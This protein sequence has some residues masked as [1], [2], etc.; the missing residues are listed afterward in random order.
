MKYNRSKIDQNDIILLISDIDQNEILSLISEI[1]QNEIL[2]L[3]SLFIAN[4]WDWLK[5]DLLCKSLNIINHLCFNQ[6]KVGC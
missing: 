2:L 5:A 1:D 6:R 3:I 4:M